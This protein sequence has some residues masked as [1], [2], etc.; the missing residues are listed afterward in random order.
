MPAGQVILENALGFTLDPEQVTENLYIESGKTVS[1][2][3][4]SGSFGTLLDPDEVVGAYR[5][6][7]YDSRDRLIHIDPFSAI[8]KVKLVVGDVTVHTFDPDYYATYGRVR[9][10]ISLAPTWWPLYSSWY[11]EIHGDV[12]LAVDADWLWPEDE[13][14]NQDFPADLLM[15]WVDLVR[16]YS[17]SSRLIRSEN[18]GTRSYSKFEARSPEDESVTKS[19]LA[20]YAGPHGTAGRLPV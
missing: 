5:L 1:D 20:R 9:K 10:Y 17:D 4:W 2:W 3:S 12:Q 14:G 13:D 6:F 19:I 7:N 18:R 15:T 11:E 8:H 16:H